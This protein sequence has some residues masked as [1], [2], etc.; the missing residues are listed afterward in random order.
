MSE[1]SAEISIREATAMDAEDIAVVH[2][3]TWRDTYA[4]LVPDDYLVRLSP[5][6]HE[7]AWR[8][9]IG[10]GRAGTVLV[11]A[12]PD[13]RIVGFGSCG[14]ARSQ[15]LGFTGEVYTLYVAPDWQDQGIG[16]RLL[17]ALFE[18]LGAKGHPDAFLWVLSG[19]P[20]RYFY[21]AMG[22]QAV[23][24]RLE[25]FAGAELEETG[26][27]WRDLPAWLAGRR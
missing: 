20:T 15:M 27:A 26:Y 14:R 11:A 23:A 24:E 18:E 2:V 12:L 17:G 19:N 3:D 16:G 1:L 8:E 6:R 13:R 7:A 25:R 10:R 22:G 21:E 5:D 9:E 4:G